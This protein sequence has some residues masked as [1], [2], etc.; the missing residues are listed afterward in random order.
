MADQAIIQS[1]MA[2][3]IERCADPMLA[4][5]AKAVAT[6]PGERARALSEMLAEEVHDR[7]LRNIVLA[8]I[9]P[10]FYP[11]SDGIES[12]I[13]PAG[14]L[15]RLW[16]IA[17]N[18]E[19]ALLHR[20]EG[21]DPGAVIVAN[22][23]CVAAAAAVRDQPDVVWPPEL[24]SPEAREQGLAELAACL[25]LCHLARQGLASLDGWLRR[26]DGDQLAEL[27]LLI[28]DSANVM[29]DGGQRILEI[30]FAHLLDAVMILRI[31]TQTSGS[32]GRE[33]FLSASELAG[34]VDRLIVGVTQRVERVG[35]YKPSE[36]SIQGVISDVNWCA[37]VLAELDATLELQP[38]SVWGRSA[39]HAR[40]AI[41]KTLNALLRTS[42]KMVD[43]ALPLVRVTITG[44]MTRQAP[45]LD[46]PLDSEAMK[47]ARKLL[48]LV[49]AVR[50][51][52]AIFGCESE[53]RQLIDALMQRLS[54]YAEEAFVAVN[55]GEGDSKHVLKLIG[56]AAEFQMLIGEKS[57][58][59]VLRRR[60][61]VASRTT[62]MA[63]TPDAL[64]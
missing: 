56:V 2:P 50:G 35:A 40:V 32:A 7:R 31:V 60:V 44:R 46:A 11:R 58:A 41:S 43:K 15:P 24:S 12:L 48:H 63:R 1:I 20:V 18:R 51:A 42:E 4:Q 49:G 16:K 8:P 30:L 25:D 27:R 37:G 26:P 22:R 29:P 55:T 19:P 39:R 5:L 9:M 61:T 62:M 59:I 57:S 6:M 54:T 38:G 34:F 64:I 36:G 17:S 21:D 23:I 47:D 10:M 33:S 28:R 45:K 13:F 52:A 3:L 14:V 53:R